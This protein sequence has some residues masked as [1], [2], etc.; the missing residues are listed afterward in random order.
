MLEEKL[1]KRNKSRADIKIFIIC[2]NQKTSVCNLSIDYEKNVYFNILFRKFRFKTLVDSTVLF[3][4]RKFLVL[5]TTM[6][7]VKLSLHLNRPGNRIAEVL[8]NGVIFQGI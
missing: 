4:R 3:F 2:E 8:F 6:T 1:Q 7:V 5:T